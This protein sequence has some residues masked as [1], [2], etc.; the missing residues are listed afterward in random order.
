MLDKGFIRELTSST[1]APLLLTA[2]LKEGIRI[3]Y[4]YRGLNNCK[5]Y[6]Y[7]C[8]GISLGQPTDTPRIAAGYV[9]GARAP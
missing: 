7:G 1:V 8:P 5:G 3:Y 6:Y 9:P 2:K 4:N